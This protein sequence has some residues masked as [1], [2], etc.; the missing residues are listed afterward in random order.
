VAEPLISLDYERTSPQPGGQAQVIVTV[1]NPGTVV[2]G[3]R[4]RVLGPMAPW[5]KVPPE[6]SVYPQPQTT[7]AV[8]ILPPTGTGVLS[9]LQPF[10]VI[11]RSTLDLSAGAG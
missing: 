9:G 11:A 5:S 7:A 2:E 8:V 6:V 10:G 3:H 4:L 1:T